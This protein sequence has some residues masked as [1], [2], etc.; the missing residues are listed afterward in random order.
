MKTINCLLGVTIISCLLVTCLSAQTEDLE[1]RFSKSDHVKSD[2]LC[3]S[4]E[5]KALD[6]DY[7]QLG[8]QT[9]RI[10]YDSNDGRFLRQSAES[11]LN[12]T[13]TL[14]VVQSVH[15]SDASGYGNIEFDSNLGFINI[16]ISD[17][18]VLEELV[19]FSQENWLSTANICFE[20][21]EES[22][23]IG[24]IWA[25]KELTNGYATAFTSVSTQYWDG[26]EVLNLLYTDNKSDENKSSNDVMVNNH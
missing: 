9:Y 26:I 25:R 18:G 11:L 13:Y 2:E 8:S 23:E 17:S 4:I 1:L 20:K 21:N 5:L 24:L 10:Y 6:K 3:Y 16:T 22:S 12:A 7:L 19:S 15:N 14:K